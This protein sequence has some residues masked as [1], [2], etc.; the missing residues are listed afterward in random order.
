MRALIRQL[1]PMLRCR[2]WCEVARTLSVVLSADR[3]PCTA[4]SSSGTACSRATC[5]SSTKTTST[6]CGAVR[7]YRRC[8]PSGCPSRPAP[9]DDRAPR[10]AETPQLPRGAQALVIRGPQQHARQNWQRV[11]NAAPVAAQLA[12]GPR[13]SRLNR[14]DPAGPAAALKLELLRSREGTTAQET[15]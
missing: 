10:K 3:E 9:T 6:G 8:R 15:T 7:R 13:G 12:T 5:A 2:Q 11:D 4:G 1:M 14:P